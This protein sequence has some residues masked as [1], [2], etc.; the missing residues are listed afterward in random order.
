MVTGVTST[1][2]VS[3]REG[4]PGIHCLGD[5]HVN[6]YVLED[7]GAPTAIDGGMQR[8]WSQL[9]DWPIRRE[10]DALA[11][12]AD[13]RLSRS[14][15]LRRPSRRIIHSAERRCTLYPGS[16]EDRRNLAEVTAVVA[17]HT[18]AAST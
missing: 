2:E 8:H 9:L 10:M 6:W 15:G 3:S 14:S 4:V 13:Q 7:K 1:R 12:E 5:S 16:F 18:I 11:H 17:S